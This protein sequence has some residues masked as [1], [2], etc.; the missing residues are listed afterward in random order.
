MRKFFTGVCTALLLA[1]LTLFWGCE[2]ADPYAAIDPTE[3][4]MRVVATV[5]DY[6]I[7]Y[8]ELRF[9]TVNAK[10]SLT[11]S[12]GVDWSDSA[13]AEKYS[14]ELSSMVWDNLLHNY[15]ILSMYDEAYDGDYTEIEE[16]LKTDVSGIIDSCGGRDE[17]IAYLAENSLADRVVRLNLRVD[18]CELELLDYYVL[19]EDINTDEETVFGEYMV[20]DGLG[21]ELIRVMHICI[22]GN[23]ESSRELARE[24]RGRI[25]LGEDVFDI[26]RE[27]SSDYSDELSGGDYLSHGDY[28]KKYE[29]VAFRLAA[30]EVSDVVEIESDCYV[31]CRLE[32][33][34]SYIIQNYSYFYQ[35]YLFSEFDKI[36]DEFDDDL[37]LEKTEFGKEIDLT[38]VN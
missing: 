37:K 19:T 26:A 3:D 4:D 13:E 6:E 15:V 31:I 11:A 5:G 7:Y 28:D 9:L 24:L 17:Y 25:A 16:R 14:D 22:E 35:K 29:D 1:V 38:K 32:K 21:A 20:Y 8:D 23:S 30:G 27:Y 36:V 10:A 18:L 12:Y 33:D 34:I 2:V